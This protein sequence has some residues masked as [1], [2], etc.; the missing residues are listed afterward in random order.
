MFITFSPRLKNKK[1]AFIS[2]KLS[3]FSHQSQYQSLS[4]LPPVCPA[5][6]FATAEQ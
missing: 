5:Y 4:L 3:D 2:I 1:L 6:A